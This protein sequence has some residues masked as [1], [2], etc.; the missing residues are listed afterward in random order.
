M[1]RPTTF[2]P[3]LYLI[4]YKP[5]VFLVCLTFGSLVS[6]KAQEP[7]APRPIEPIPSVT[8]IDPTK[9][10]QDATAG[11]AQNSAPQLT[12]RIPRGEERY[13]LGPGDTV[14]VTVFRYPELSR[15]V[16]I[17]GD[18]TIRL[19]LIRSDIPASC[20]T[21]EQ[22][23]TE[24]AKRYLDYLKDPQVDISI[25][26][27]SS[28][29]VAVVG[30]VNKPGSFALQRRVRLREILAFAGGPSPAA[31]RL[32]QIMHDDSGNPACQPVTSIAATGDPSQSATAAKPAAASDSSSSAGTPTAAKGDDKTAAASVKNAA[33]EA[34]T[35]GAA[36]ITSS[37]PVPTPTT[38]TNA[39]PA[40]GV[41][42]VDLVDLMQ[43]GGT[44]PYIR[45]GD[46]INIPEA[47]SAFVV[48]DVNHPTVVPLNKQIMLSRAIA[49]AGGPTANASSKV[50]IV[51]YI[52]TK[53]GNTEI[54][55]NLKDIYSN[56]TEDV[57]LRAGDI[58]QVPGSTAKSLTK[59]ILWMG[60]WWSVYNAYNI[61]Q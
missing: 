12:Y 38:A 7:S 61:I 11:A 47:S 39:L 35:S 32:V 29:P 21:A 28:E 50:R 24:V 48:G 57:A 30:A 13:L 51:R 44:D 55:V 46:I 42:Y 58:V 10:A 33:A 20:L 6:A 54:V 8:A 59:A 41:T 1:T 49:L 4:R 2:S 16:R 37:G 14:L 52:D 15:A 56:K 40:A 60:A 25:R 53:G 17:E 23:S 26:D 18:G 27:Y 3:S 9:A 22:L 19:P 34:G 43:G 31:G 5:A 45:P 36:T